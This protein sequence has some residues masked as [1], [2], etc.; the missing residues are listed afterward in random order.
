MRDLDSE[1]VTKYNAI[2]NKLLRLETDEYGESN[3]LCF[4]EQAEE[5]CLT[6]TITML[7]RSMMSPMTDSYF[8]KTGYLF[9]PFC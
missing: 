9:L 1:I 8:T 7:K 6:G 4:T 5:R 2:I 3:I